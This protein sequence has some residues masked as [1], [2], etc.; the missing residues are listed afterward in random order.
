MGWLVRTGVSCVALLGAASA[1]A[2]DMA[3]IAKAP[4]VPMARWHGFYIGAQLG[5]A[6]GHSDSSGYDGPLFPA[7]LLPG[8]PLLLIPGVTGSLPGAS[9]SDTS[10]L[11]GAQIGYNWQ[12]GGYVFGLE[13]DIAG[14]GL[15]TTASATADR[16]G[17]QTVTLGATTDI[18]WIATLRGR[19][20][21]ATDRW[22]L[23]VT[24][25]LAVTRL[26]TTGIGIS[27]FGPAVLL[28]V[29]GTYTSTTS[30]SHTRAG[31]TV[32]VG[33]EWAIDQAWSLGA[34]YRHVDFG[35]VTVAAAIPDGIGTTF[36]TAAQDVDVTV[37]Q[38][39]AR[40][41]YRFPPR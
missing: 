6:R 13:A 23:Y 5:G 30:E 1:Q 22:L 4:P 26:D 38:V 11:G 12:L 9:D 41:N 20:G 39:T 21:F 17:L 14:T 8:P 7:I 15:G 36:A 3:V 19:L 29:P 33:F 34:E 37:D 2:A 40:V 18:D 32:G 35:S 24:G 10:F 28:P 16:F 31:W 27:T 25:G